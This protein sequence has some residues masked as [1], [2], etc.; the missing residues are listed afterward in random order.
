MEQQ[1]P[2]MKQKRNHRPRDCLLLPENTWK[3]MKELRLQLS[4]GRG[5]EEL[6]GAAWPA[7]PWQRTF[8]NHSWKR[9]C[10]IYTFRCEESKATLFIC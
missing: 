7:S 4:D 5:S 2:S 1:F 6:L 10:L 9:G 3:T 8:E